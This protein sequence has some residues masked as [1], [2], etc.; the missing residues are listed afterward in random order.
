MERHEKQNSQLVAALTGCA[1]VL[2]LFS[3]GLKSPGESGPLPSLG[4]EEIRSGLPARLTIPSIGVDTALESVG[5][6][7]KGAMDVPTGPVNAAWFS[8]GPRPGEEGSAVIAGHYG[9]KDGLPAVFDNLSALQRGDTVYVE[10]ENGVRTAFVVRE[11]RIYGEY[12]DVPE[13]FGSLDGKAHLNL[14]T[15]GGAWNTVSRS[16]AKRLVVFAD[17]E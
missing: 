7:P 1:L 6:T 5:L 17:K 13:V 2:I 10:D 14:V 3:F 11:L 16:Y 4:E 9:W 15:C 12:E 8:L